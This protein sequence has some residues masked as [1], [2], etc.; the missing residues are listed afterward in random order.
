MVPIWLWLIAGALAV[1]DNRLAVTADPEASGEN[2]PP[3]PID[4]D[5][6]APVVSDPDGHASSVPTPESPN[7]PE[8]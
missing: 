8:S 7:P 5:T 4:T 6:P 1:L 3:A 2:K